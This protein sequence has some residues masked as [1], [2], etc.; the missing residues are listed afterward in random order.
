MKEKSDKSLFGLRFYGFMIERNHWVAG[1]ASPPDGWGF[2][3]KSTT[4]I[5]NVLCIN[6]KIYLT[7]FSVLFIFCPLTLCTL[8][9]KDKQ[10]KRRLIILSIDGFPGYYAD[11]ES[12]FAGLTPALDEL[13]SR[14]KFS[15]KIRSVYPTMTYPSHTSMITGV[16]PAL[17]GIWYNSPIDP[18]GKNQ[19]G[20]MWYDEDIR[21]R[22]ITDFAEIAGKR[23]ASVYWPVS[24]GADIDFNIP[25]YW[26]SKIPED[27]KI[28]RALSTNGLYDELKSKTG[29]VVSEITGDEEKIKNGVELWKL[30]KPDLLMIYSTDLDT[31]HHNKG[32]YSEEA[33][34]KLIKI[35]FLLGYLIKETKLYEKKNV[36]LIVVSDHG[37]KE[38]NGICYPNTE[39]KK[40]GHIIPE[41]EVWKYFFR[42]MGGVSILLKNEK[43]ADKISRNEIVSLGRRIA[44]GC[45]GAVFESEGDPMFDRILKKFNSNALAVIYSNGNTGFGEKSDNSLFK[46]LE[47]PV[48][49]HGFLPTDPSMFTILLAY[50][51][52][53][54]TKLRSVKDVFR[55]S[56]DWLK[57]SCRRG[58]S[59]Y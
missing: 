48:S 1:G 58:E 36:G 11:P 14:S 54:N 49:T 40:A 32:I 2:I 52:Q 10:L 53:K 51:D 5:A 42:T 27:E 50:P 35:D 12:P 4:I 55:L 45:P 7:L 33:K 19:G 17:H 57:I 25:Q 23:T 6:L 43:S 59:R 9:A 24:V 29:L 22:T 56:C 18:F 8:S 34:K 15:N 26:R 3:L 20:W 30:K 16:D 39:L 46:K 44:E 37:F 38:M 47:T 31:A 28:V 21:V 13:K 41:K